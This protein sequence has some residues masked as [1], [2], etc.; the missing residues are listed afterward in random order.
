PDPQ[1]SLARDIPFTGAYTSSAFALGLSY[2]INALITYSTNKAAAEAD[3]DKAHLNLLWQEWQIVAKSRVL[4]AKITQE[5]AVM[6]VLV[7]NRAL[8]TDRYQRTRQALD[9]GLL[10]LDAVTPHLTALQDM[11]RQINDLERQ[12]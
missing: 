8:V 5:D 9:E 2:A 6:N 7:E 4:F 12:L 3:L 1:V 10:T 11:Q